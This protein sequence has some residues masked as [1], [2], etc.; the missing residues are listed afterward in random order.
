MPPEHAHPCRPRRRFREVQR[1]ALLVDH[2]AQVLVDFGIDAAQV[3]G[4]EALPA[5][6][7]QPLED[8][9]DA[10]EVLAVDL[11]ALVEHPTQG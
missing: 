1:S 11:E 10:L 8:L 9:P 6:P 5:G 3:I 7:S 4:L 2:V